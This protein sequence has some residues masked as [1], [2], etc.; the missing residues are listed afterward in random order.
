MPATSATTISLGLCYHG[1]FA[2]TGDRCPPMY[3][4][5]VVVALPLWQRFDYRVSAAEYARLQPG[6][7]VR[8]SF[9][10]RLL[11]GMVVAKTPTSASPEP[12]LKPIEAILDT[13]PLL[14]PALLELA[15][16]AAD[17]YKHPPGE[18][19]LQALPVLLRQGAAA[20]S[21]PE[22]RWHESALGRLHEPASLPKAPR[23]R[24]AWQALRDEP[25]GLSLQ[26]AQVLGIELRDL[27][28]LAKR[29]YAETRSHQPLPPAMHG[30]ADAALPANAEQALA[31][32]SVLADQGFQVSLLQGITGSGKT[33]VYLQII[34]RILERGQQALVLVPEISLTPQTLQR[35][36]QRFLCPVLGLHSGLSDR[37]R[38]HA[39]QQAAEG[40]A[41]III[42]TRS[43]LF[44]P[45]PR[46]GLII[47][48]EEHDPS[49]K[50]GEGFR[51]HARDLAVVRARL[52][53]IPIVLGSATPSLESLHN[54]ELGRYRLLHLRLRSNQLQLPRL[55]LLEMRGLNLYE[56]LAPSAL[57]S[58]QE[59]LERGHQ[60]L[61]FLNR[62]GYAPILLCHDCGWRMPC[63]RCSTSPVWHRRLGRVVCHHCGI[64]QALPER[65]GACGSR[66]LRPLGIGTEKLQEALSL[67]FP[68]FPLWRIDR[69]SVRSPRELELRLQAIHRH[70][71]G[72]LLGTQMLA[73]GHHFAAVTLVLIVDIDAAL[74]AT[75]FRALERCAQLI[76]QVAGR[77][78]RGNHA[79]EVILQTHHREHPLLQLLVEQ[80]YES[81]AAALL[82]ERA[83][84]GLPP[85]SHQA[86]LLA[87]GPQA[88]QAEDHLTALAT[89]VPA[90][91]A[92]YGV[93]AAPIERKA[94]L[95]RAHLLLQ[96]ASR[97]AL[98][99]AL[100][101]LVHA[102][103]EDK[104]ARL[105]C[106]IDVD[107]QDLS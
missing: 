53:N 17:Y 38:L 25:A 33:E 78:G 64:S 81:F 26:M 36:R 87:Q 11:V 43:A 3:C 9:G 84:M 35:F 58:L 6:M 31:R 1:P 94:G 65:C 40:R 62:R 100:Q 18:V 57:Q 30:L 50:Q 41:G 19:Y 55:H 27:R 88:Q 16:F 101:T 75:D 85:Y 72:I 95:F 45:L 63:P 71:P 47:V 12:S 14:S 34:E 89:H 8:V 73:K 106:W 44:T 69:D 96:S 90:H 97:P 28:A 10:R 2:Q 15:R 51:Y 70:Q 92:P 79:G 93:I 42:G 7:R 82:S 39:W 103:Q 24:A 105:R 86:L 29:G 68:D 52:E 76:I 32:D 49:F 80:G 66:D 21:E 99:Q 56:G 91:L 54:V 74:F 102:C 60:V 20:H 59:H 48:D 77:A 37:E 5:Q 4:I 23:Q 98:Q 46:L 61:V 22:L 107:P 67:R 13:Q 104:P 83:A